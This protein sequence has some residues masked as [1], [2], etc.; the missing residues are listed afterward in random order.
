MPEETKTPSKNASQKMPHELPG[1]FQ[2]FKPSE[3]I[4]LANLPTYLALAGV[5][6]LLS[7]ISGFSRHNYYSVNASATL[8]PH[9]IL[10]LVNLIGWLISIAFAPG[11]I[12]LQLATI[13]KKTLG[14]NEAFQQGLTYLWRFILLGIVMIVLLIVSLIL[15]IVP[16][17]FVLPRVILAPY[18]LIDR[19][20]SVTEA[21]NASNEAYK[22]RGK[23]WGIIGVTILLNVPSLIPVIG[24]VISAVLTFLYGPAFAMRYEQYKLLEAGKLPQTPAEADVVNDRKA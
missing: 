19:D 9:G 2:L 12:C 18:Y 15:F 17:F 6:S 13:N 11:L 4:V 16:F 24:S 23:L 8:T 21:L 22:E 1:A 20:L 3:R 7:I 5:P 14:F 10:A